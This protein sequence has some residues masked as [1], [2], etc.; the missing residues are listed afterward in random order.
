[1]RLGIAKPENFVFICLCTRLSLSLY[2]KSNRLP[3]E[4]PY[5]SRHMALPFMGLS[6]TKYCL[7][8]KWHHCLLR[9][10]VGFGRRGRR[11]HV[12]FSPIGLLPHIFSHGRF[13]KRRSFGLFI[14]TSRNWRCALYNTYR[15]PVPHSCPP[16]AFGRLPDIPF[17][18]REEQEDRKSRV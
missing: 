16:R 2:I 18:P 9:Y 6:R 13:G 7:G 11:L 3:H 15:N 10:G 8:T 5:I 17:P 4:T 12:E 14:R 1:M